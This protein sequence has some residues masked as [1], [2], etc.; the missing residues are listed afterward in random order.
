MTSGAA[1]GW[2]VFSADTRL[3]VIAPHPD[4]ETIATGLLLQQVCAA[5]GAVRIVLLTAG[6]NNPWPQRWLERRWRIRA[7]DRQRWAWRRGAELQQALAALGIPLAALQTLAWPDLGVTDMLL[8]ATARAVTTVRAAIDQFMPDLVVL[9]SL[10]D[11]HPDHGAAHVLVRLALAGRSAPPALFTYLVHGKSAARRPHQLDATAAQVTGKREALQAYRS[12]LALSGKRLRRLAERP[13]RYVGAGD[14]PRSVRAGLPWRPPSWLQRWLRLSVVDPAGVHDWAWPDVPWQPAA[15][16]GLHLLSG[17]GEC[18]APR[19][20]RL[21]LNLPSP[22]IFDRWG[23]C[24]LQACAGTP[25]T[26]VA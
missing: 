23:W 9:P 24:E 21:S 11:R 16:G 2:P 25:V 19:F 26:A 17:A 14:Q 6:E 3:L 12:Q 1:G 22:W 7:A 15:D 10:H 13:E 4:D 20:A 8:H 18:S 5:G